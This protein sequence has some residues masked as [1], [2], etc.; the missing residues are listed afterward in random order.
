MVIMNQNAEEKVVITKR[1]V[2]NMTGFS[3]GKNILTDAVMAD[4]NSITVPAMSI[5]VI[6][7][8]K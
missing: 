2:E 5:Q 7:L 6:E 1:F 4:I 3:K 8:M